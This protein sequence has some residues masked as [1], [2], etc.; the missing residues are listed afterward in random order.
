MQPDEQLPCHLTLTPLSIERI[1][2]S[3]LHRNRHVA[4]EIAGPRYCPSIES[5]VLRFPGR[6]HHVWLEPEGIESDLVYPGGLSCTL[7]EEEQVRLVR[8]VPGLQNAEVVRPGYGVEYEY[9]DPR[10]LRTSFE[11]KRVAGLFLAGQINGTTGYEEAAAQ[12]VVAG[13]NAAAAAQRKP[14]LAINRT[15]GYIG[16]LV[17]DLTA[18]GTTEPYRMFTSR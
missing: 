14:P 5:K 12:G 6:R 3:N 1:V 13:I 16:V 11:L 10:E 9:V 2:R 8:S 18:R 17:D 4:T 7:P 15:D